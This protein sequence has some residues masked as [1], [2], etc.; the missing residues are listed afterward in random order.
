MRV[1]DKWVRQKVVHAVK[2]IEPDPAYEVGLATHLRDSMGKSGVA[3]L[4]GRFSTG[5]SAFDA[6]MRRV[7][8]RALAR[9][10]GDGLTVET[11]ATFRHLERIEIGSGV[12][13]GAMCFLQGRF[14]SNCRIGDR[15]WIGPHAHIDARDLIIEEDAALG[16]GVRVIAVEHTGET[17]PRGLNATD[18]MVGPIRICRGAGVSTGTIVM[19]GVTV[20]ADA[21]IGAGSVIT[22]DIP[23]RGVAMGVPARVVRVRSPDQDSRS[24]N[25]SSVQGQ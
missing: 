18:M 19:P 11:G 16:P 9:R 15:V 17:H 7:I 2:D 21:W 8:W 12:H 4:Y 6:M 3:E 23:E 5:T 10:C 13:F 1:K 24:A 20:G 25:R 22:S 14:D